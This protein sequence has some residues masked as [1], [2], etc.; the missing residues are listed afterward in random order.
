MGSFEARIVIVLL[1]LQLWFISPSLQQ[2]HGRL[3]STVDLPYFFNNLKSPKLLLSPHENHADVTREPRSHGI[4]WKFR[5]TLAEKGSS[6]KR[7]ALTGLHLSGLEIIKTRNGG[8]NE[9]ILKSTST[10]EVPSQRHSIRRRKSFSIPREMGLRIRQTE[11][12]HKQVSRPKKILKQSRYNGVGYMLSKLRNEVMHSA[13]QVTFMTKDKEKA[14]N[15]THI[16]RN[17]PLKAERR[18][19]IFN[20]RST[21]IRRKRR[22]R[23]VIFRRELFSKYNDQRTEILKASIRTGCPSSCRCLYRPDSMVD[24]VDCSSKGLTMIPKLPTSAREVQLQNNEISTIPSGTFRYMDKLSKMDLSK[25]RLTMLKKNTFKGLIS[26]GSLS[27]QDNR[28]RY[29]PG[30]FATGAFQG[31]VSLEVLRLNGNQ[32]DYPDN[33]VYPDQALAQVPTLKRLWLD[34]FP[35][36]LGP[37]FS[38]LTQL[39]FLSFSA[40]EGSVCW[41]KSDIPPH[42]FNHLNSKQPLHIDFS[43]CG[44]Y[45]IPPTLF[46]P[47]PTIHTLDLSWNQAFNI[48][49][50]ERASEGLQN[51][52]LTVL[53][54]TRLSN[55][56][57]HYSQIKSTTFRFLKNTTLKMLL[58]ENVDIIEISPQAILDLPKT[59]EYISFRDNKVIYPQFLL[60]LTPLINLKVGIFSDQLKVSSSR[61]P[62][63]HRP[64]LFSKD[65]DSMLKLHTQRNSSSGQNPSTN[66]IG[67]Q[68]LFKVGKTFYSSVNLTRAW[69][70]SV[71]D[72]CSNSTKA[73]A[74][75]DKEQRYETNPLPLPLPVSLEEGYFANIKVDYDIPEVHIF[76]NKVLRYLDYSSNGVKCFG[77]PIY[78]VPSLQY[79]DLSKNWCLKLNP[80]F[81]SH[82]PRLKT[83]LLNKNMLG[84]SLA[85]DVGGK[86]FSTLISLE[87]LDLSYNGVEHLSALAFTGCRNLKLLNLSNNELIQFRPSLATNNKLETLDL[88]SNALAGF[89]QSNCNQMLAIKEKNPNFT[90]WIGGKTSFLCDCD[91]FYFLNFILDHP[92]IFQGAESFHCKQANGANVSYAQLAHFLPQLGVEC[93]IQPVFYGVVI[94][95]LLLVGT[96]A[97]CA[98]YHYK[99]WQWKYLYYVGRNRLHIGSMHLTYRPVANVFVTY[100]QVRARERERERERVKSESERESGKKRVGERERER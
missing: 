74:G 96:L 79:L 51:S 66:Q 30:T 27:L 8:I 100:D 65:S 20:L 59:L 7:D 10:S 72:F 99:R 60:T 4:S 1:Y 17:Y 77:G 93:V 97:F 11:L 52:T 71:S 35:R 67:F 53:N 81:F 19:D 80:L 76:N 82:M 56:S 90:V 42:F 36:S 21:E 68:Q 23:S 29:L 38:A 44:F 54:I 58:V 75:K 40:F 37:G 92:A 13:N 62:Y 22:R 34:G 32:P 98:L 5:P 2:Q 48:D 24:I 9:Q 12:N 78:G 69:A 26:L 85:D 73:K 6:P 84:R 83:L 16:I 47:V 31:M 86:T 70:T 57:A 55:N 87:T 95:F 14:H 63:F 25:N 91:H 45:S 46:N 28:L 50:F 15:Q 61:N 89:T 49:N 33:F 39:S 41:M 88:S 43:A 94:A 64:F 18:K 3:D